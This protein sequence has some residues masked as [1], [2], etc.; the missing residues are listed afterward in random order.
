VSPSGHRSGRLYEWEPAHHPDE[1][2]L[3][4]APPWL[5]QLVLAQTNGHG[6]TPPV[7]EIIPESRRNHTLTSIAGSMRRRGMTAEEI[8]IALRA[9]NERRCVPPLADA[10]LHAIAESVGRYA[11]AE[12]PA[13]D[14]DYLEDILDFIAEPDPP[15]SVIFPGLLPAGVI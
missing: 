3:A 5:V 12:E 9:V 13:D 7:D 4:L 11:P 2:P 1:I 10:E 8:C 14:L 6:P 15:V